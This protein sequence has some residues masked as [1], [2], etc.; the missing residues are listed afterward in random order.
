VRINVADRAAFDA[1]QARSREILAELWR[2]AE[3][4]VRA[5]PDS[6]SVGLYIE[7]L[8][9]T[10]DIEN[11]RTV[12]IVYAR[13]PDTVLIM[14]FLGEILTMA[15]VG[16]SA[17]LQGSRGLLTAVVLVIVLGAILTLLVDLDRPREGFLQV[18]QRP[19]ID[20]AE[21]IGR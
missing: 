12:A 7:T 4:L 17:G 1:N 20:L 14:L 11:A 21:Q 8:N 18:S 16:Y 6:V 3:G 10:I 15:V 5:N 19:L 13:V 2:Q 9:A